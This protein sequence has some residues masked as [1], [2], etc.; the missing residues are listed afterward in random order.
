MWWYMPSGDA[1]QQYK[2]WPFRTFSL[3]LMSLVENCSGISSKTN[4]GGHPFPLNHDC[5]RKR[6][7]HPF[8]NI[9]NFVTPCCLCHGVNSLSLVVQNLMI[10]LFISTSFGFLDFLIP[11]TYQNNQWGLKTTTFIRQ[12]LNPRS[13]TLLN[14]IHHRSQSM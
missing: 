7:P 5:R 4:L 3:I 11:S 14:L 9:Y 10:G 12:N 6:L 8:S 1:Y 13:A 2:K